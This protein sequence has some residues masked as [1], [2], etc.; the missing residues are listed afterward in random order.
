PSIGVSSL[1][2]PNRSADPAAGTTAT[3]RSLG[4]PAPA[5]PWLAAITQGPEGALGEHARGALAL[6]D[7]PRRVVHRPRR[8]VHRVRGGRDGLVFEA[9]A[10][11]RL[12]G[13]SDEHGPRRNGG[14]RDARVADGRALETHGR[15]EADDGEVERGA[16]A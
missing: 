12:R 14:D 5:A 3:V 15:G 8:L 16:I 13:G 11:D 10:D 9:R 7:R 1:R 2:P 6:R 4:G